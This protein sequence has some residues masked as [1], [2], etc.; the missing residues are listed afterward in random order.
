MQ[1]HNLIQGSPEWHAHRARFRNASDAPAMM[2]VSPYKT[3][4][5]LIRELATGV[6]QT[7]DAQKQRIFDEGHR[8]EVLA[9]PIA[10]AILGEELYPVVGSEGTLSASFDGLTMLEEDGWEHKSL[11]D[12]LRA[13]MVDGCTGADLPMVYQVQLEH[14]CMVSK[15]TRRILFQA[16]K[17]EGDVLIE[18]RHCWYTPNP[19]LANRIRLGWEA[20]NKDVAAYEPEATEPTVIAAAVRALPALVVRMQGEVTECNLDAYRQAASAF[21]SKIKTDLKTDQDFADAELVVKACSEGEDRLELVKS[22]A[23][24]QTV[25]IDEVFRTIDLIKEEMRQKRLVLE[26]AVKSRKDAIRVEIFEE[27][28]TQLNEHRAALNKR[29]G[30]DWI[31][32]VSGDFAGAM[33]GKRTVK[34]CR[35]AAGE[36]LLRHRIDLSALADKLDANRKALRTEAQDWF[37]LF[38][39]FATVGQKATDDFAAVAA[40]R[41]KAHQ[42]AEAEAERARLAKVAADAVAA[43]EAEKQAPAAPPAA[44]PA[45]PPTQQPAAEPLQLFAVSYGTSTAKSAMVNLGAVC[46][47]LGF[48]VT[49]EFL[50]S[51]G[52]K[53]VTDRSAK[54]YRADDLPAICDALIAHLQAKRDVRLAA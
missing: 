44:A 48:I 36:L 10:E 6:G 29:L 42:D 35:E 12:E 34:G 45:A 15:Q 25:T 26:K 33:K 3:R 9:R 30:A 13:V 43:A 37:F 32:H 23:L 40:L 4:A 27:H 52:F 38:A 22:Q 21:L 14:Q 47:H 54:Q 51:I 7:I 1:T 53:A 28:Q 19:D 8:R 18:E 50:E 41:I 11:N 2:G 17:W 5:E 39:D 24:A 46:K 49:S 16:S 31:A 20:L